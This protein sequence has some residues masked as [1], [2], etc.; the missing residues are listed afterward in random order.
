MVF[1]IHLC[2]LGYLANKSSNAPS[3]VGWLLIGTGI[4]CLLS[5]GG[6]LAEFD[7]TEIEPI[8]A[9]LMIIGEL[10]FAVWL[11]A[12][13]IDN[14]ERAILRD[15]DIDK[16]SLNFLQVFQ[17]VL[18]AAAGIQNHENRARDISR[19]DPIHFIL[20]GLALT[21]SFVVGVVSVVDI[22][23]GKPA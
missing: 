6:R 13:R 20:M 3:A 4:S 15:T 9:A 10:S 18:W 16:R 17:S 12:R 8:L 2:S 14:E 19:G 1:V 22:V 23:C 5:R 11:I 21:V 7:L